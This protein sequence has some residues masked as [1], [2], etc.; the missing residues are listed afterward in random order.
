MGTVREEPGHSGRVD[1]RS[2]CQ[3]RD[4]DRVARLGGVT[5]WEAVCSIRLP[6]KNSPV[7]SG[8]PSCEHIRVL[9]AWWSRVPHHCL[10]GVYRN[11]QLFVE[12]KDPS[13]A[14]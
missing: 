4:Q 12:N 2:Q 13:N 14:L 3:P 5:L 11:S 6:K 1:G 9:G 8:L 10:S 7:A